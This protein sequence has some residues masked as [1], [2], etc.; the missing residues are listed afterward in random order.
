RR[1][2]LV[3][4]AE[5]RNQVNRI[6]LQ[7]RTIFL[8]RL[9]QTEYAL[10]RRSP[11]VVAAAIRQEVARRMPYL[12]AATL[13]EISPA[14]VN[15]ALLVDPLRLGLVDDLSQTGEASVPFY[16][17]SGRHQRL[18]ASLFL[19]RYE[20]GLSQAR[21]SSNEEALNAALPNGVP[22]PRVMYLPQA[23][24]QYRLV[25][26]DR[27]TGDMM[28]TRVGTADNWATASLPST[29]FAM[30]DFTDVYQLP[31]QNAADPVL[32]KN[33]N[34]NVDTDVLGWDQALL[35]IA[36]AG[37]INVLSDAYLRPD[38]FRPEEKGPI[39]V[40]TTL[41]ETLDRVADYYGYTWWK[42]GDWYLFRSKLFGDLERTTVPPRVTRL[43]SQ[44]LVAG[45]RLSAEA[46][47]ALAA[48]TPE[49]LVTMHLYSR[50]AGQPFAPAQSYDLNNIELSR[51]GLMVYSQ[52]TP[53]QRELAR[54]A[55]LPF[56]LL[57]PQQQYLFTLAAYDRGLILSPYD[58]ELWR[59][60]VREQFEREKLPA[61]W[62]QLGNMRFAFDY[63]GITRTADLG[64]RA[65]ALEPPQEAA[66]GSE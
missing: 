59:F 21:L 57:P 50:S 13:D 53:A 22:D 4:S 6:R 56:V 3:S 33:V 12:P 14:Y 34:V 37:K 7:R 35:A 9:L 17:L 2:K 23:R 61:G 30:P 11:D 62:A 66:K 26:G 54:G 32:D 20:D 36:R 18:L 60:R 46:L 63:A 19:E 65:P 10:T 16:R 28:V 1:Y 25:F 43:V 48:L 55:G 24:L 64:L 44:S 41:R 40:G 51:V 15:Q 8:N 42:Q 58:Q 38:V 5:L 47:A 45:D 31:P 39:V 52:L 29:L 27:W 49:Q